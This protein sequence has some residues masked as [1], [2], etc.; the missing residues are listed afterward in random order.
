MAPNIQVWGCV[1]DGGYV[2]RDIDLVKGSTYKDIIKG[3]HSF[4]QGIGNQVFIVFDGYLKSNTKDQ[5]HEKRNP[6]QSLRIEITEDMTN[7]CSKDLF[8]S[9]PE[10]KQQFIDMLG[11][12]LQL[13]IMLHSTTMMLSLWSKQLSYPRSAMYVSFLMTLICLLC[14]CHN[15]RNQHQTVYI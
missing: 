5:T 3:Y 9:N 7:D 10:N 11:V 13:D 14:C 15:F 4:V 8:L 1:L 6:I 12:F 2:L